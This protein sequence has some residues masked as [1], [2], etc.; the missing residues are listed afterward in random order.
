MT[1]PDCGLFS[2]Y[3]IPR[4]FLFLTR[5][6]RFDTQYPLTRISEKTYLLYWSF[7]VIIIGIR[8]GKSFIYLLLDFFKIKMFTYKEIWLC[9]L[10]L[11]LNYLCFILYLQCKWF[12]LHQ[13]GE[14]WSDVPYLKFFI[15]KLFVVFKDHSI[16]WVLVPADTRGCSIRK[17]RGIAL[18]LFLT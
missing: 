9:F 18:S 15:I 10:S 17:E 3:S 7:N 16:T 14:L 2:Y 5:W 13:R 12:F 4:Y 11:G 6:H 1:L 8:F